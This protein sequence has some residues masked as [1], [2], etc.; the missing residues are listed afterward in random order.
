MIRMSLVTHAIVAS[1]LLMLVFPASAARLI[2]ENTTPTFRGESSNVCLA[3]AEGE[4][5][6]AGLQTNL[7][8]DDRCL[9]PT[10]ALRPC[11][12]APESGKTVQAALQ[13]RGELKAIV[14]SFTDTNPIPDGRMLC[15]SFMAVGGPGERCTVRASRIIGSTATGMRVDDIQLANDAVIAISGGNF[16]PTAAAVLGQ[17]SDDGCAIRESGPASGAACLLV[18]VAILLAAARGRRVRLPT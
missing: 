6:I 10:N 5:R 7:A 3:L 1:V 2:F 15:C 4:D 12:A 14:I 11:L 17:V 9:T 13:G 8:W 16:E 18:S